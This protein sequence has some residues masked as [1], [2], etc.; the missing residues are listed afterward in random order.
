MI[1]IHAD[2]DYPPDVDYQNTQGLIFVIDSND[3]DR[4]AEAREE[5]HALLEHDDLKDSLLL[6]FANKQDLPHA[7]NAA[8][9]TDKLGLRTLR[10]RE[11]YIQVSAW[12]RLHGPLLTLVP[13]VCLC[14][15][16]RR[17]V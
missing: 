6:V 10:Q 12:D 14:H 13:A 2:A 9:L 5:L 15:E 8:A 7:M 4:V 17:A 16:R 3:V 11:W 1:A